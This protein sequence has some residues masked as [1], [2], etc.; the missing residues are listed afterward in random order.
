MPEYPHAQHPHGV[1]SPTYAYPPT[2]T[3]PGPEYGAPGPQMA[4][5]YPQ[6]PPSQH[7]FMVHPSMYQQQHHPQQPPPTEPRR[8]MPPSEGSMNMG[9]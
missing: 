4:Y 3:G 7:G 5:G 2:P 6:G 8:M 9:M 1:P